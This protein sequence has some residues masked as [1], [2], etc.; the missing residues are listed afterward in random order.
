MIYLHTYKYMHIQFCRQFHL[1]NMPSI[2]EGLVHMLL[3]GNEDGV[4]WA[5]VALSYIAHKNDDNV[6][7]LGQC[8]GLFSGLL[9][10]L[11]MSESS[12]VACGVISQVRLGRRGT[13]GDLF[14]RMLRIYVYVDIMRTSL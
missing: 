4:Y 10:A 11:R 3:N 9:R 6:T 1:S 8:R 14:V 12:S 2:H 13:V 7:Q 5:C